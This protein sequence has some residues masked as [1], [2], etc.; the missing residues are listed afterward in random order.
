MVSPDRMLYV[1]SNTVSL[2]VNFL[3]L[4]VTSASTE[5]EIE[6]CGIADVCVSVPS[7]LPNVVEQPEKA[8][9]TTTPKKIQ[10]FIIIH[11]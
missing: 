3:T 8:S 6:N 9:I 5:V 1:D 10:E 2:D 4:T 11:I 7:L